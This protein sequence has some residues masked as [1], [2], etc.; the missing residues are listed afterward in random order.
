MVHTVRKVAQILELFSVEQP[1]WGVREVG[2]ALEI[3]KSTA[4]A[5]MDSLAEQRLL[6]R[7]DKGRYQ[8]GWRLFELSQTLLDH[9][10]IRT[11][12]R[13]VMQ[14]LASRWRETTHLA[15]LDGAQAVY[16]EKLP[17]VSAIKTLASRKGARQPAHCSAVGKVLLANR[18][19]EDT[20][21][22][23][24]H[25]G[26]PVFTP[27]TI[28]T[29]EKLARE[30]EEIRKRGYGYDNEEASAGVCCVAAPIYN[31]GHG[32]IASVSLA[33]PTHRFETKREQY[34]AAILE[35]AERI[36]RSAN[37]GMETYTEVPELRVR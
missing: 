16:I 17:R 8:L 2:R 35:A 9:T 37:R 20:A 36:S 6:Q 3:P 31:S 12:A 34:T 15:T 28:S 14:D 29:L 5:L 13:A 21:L 1:E 25:Q 33:V 27:N 26:M 18:D 32:V 7:T 24:K 23:L 22:L 10:Q 4:H 11:A 30:L 19:W